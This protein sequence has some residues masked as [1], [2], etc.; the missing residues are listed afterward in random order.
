M[1]VSLNRVLD[2]VVEFIETGIM[3]GMND[4][5]E[6][7][8]RIALGRIYDSRENLKS[9]LTNTG[10]IRTFALIDDEGNVD[11]DRLAADL[12][13]EVERKGKLEVN[14]KMFGKMKFDAGDVERLRRLITQEGT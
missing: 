12:K 2:G 3:P 10:Y 8:A 1:K 7:A 6:I 5:Q 14:L 9:Y 11:I 13:R 4:W